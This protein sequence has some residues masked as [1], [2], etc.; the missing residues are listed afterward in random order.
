MNEKV[1][2]ITGL[3]TVIFRSVDR[4][5]RLP[6]RP[7]GAAQR[8]DAELQASAADRLHVHDV[9]QIIHVGQDEILL[10]RGGGLDRR[11]EWHAL[12]VGVSAAQQFV[13]AILNPRRDVG[14]RRARHS[15]GCT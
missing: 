1:G 5:D 4:I 10:M 14:V 15:A 2:S 8:I 6:V 12:D 3:T 11:G 9:A 13:G 7:G